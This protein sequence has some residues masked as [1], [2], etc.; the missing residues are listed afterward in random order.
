MT[1][2]CTASARHMHEP[3]T[4]GWKLNR[5]NPRTS[6]SAASDAG[7]KARRSGARLITDCHADRKAAMRGT[8]PQREAA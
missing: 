3:H 2:A 1:V 6:Q 4:G 5:K 7:R 8:V